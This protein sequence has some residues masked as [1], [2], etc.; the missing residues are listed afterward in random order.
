MVNSQDASALFFADKLVTVTGEPADMHAYAHCLFRAGQ[1]SRALFH[2]EKRDLLAPRLVSFRLIAVR[3]LAAL[4]NWDDC[5]T[6]IEGTIGNSVAEAKSVA[7]NY[8]AAE[9]R[10]TWVPGDSIHEVASLCCLRADVLVAM[11][12]RARAIEWCV[13]DCCRDSVFCFSFTR[14]ALL[15]FCCCCRC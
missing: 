5:L 10:N 1:Y 13:F 11:E 6:V 9:K 4:S 14:V 2:L 3:C 15:W 12:N 7:R 8:T